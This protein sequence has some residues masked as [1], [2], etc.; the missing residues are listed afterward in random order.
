[1]DNLPDNAKRYIDAL[2]DIIGVDFMT[3]ST[4]PERHQTIQIEGLF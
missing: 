4:G 1:M 2:R 3:I